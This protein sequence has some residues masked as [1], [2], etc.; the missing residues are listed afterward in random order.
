MTFLILISPATVKERVSTTVGPDLNT[1]TSGRTHDI[2]IPLAKEYTY[3]YKGVLVGKGR[4]AIFTSS[5]YE[6]KMIWQA[7]HPH[8]M[9]FELI[10]DSGL[11]GF[12]IMI[13]IFSIVGMNIFKSVSAIKDNKL[14]YYQCAIIVSIIAYL[15]TGLTGRSL[16]PILANSYF[17]IVLGCGIAISRMN[18]DGVEG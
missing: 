14:R 1:A 6:N 4:F 11:L 18:L 8:N 5:T 7:A 2:W 13:G 12:F 17:W 3:D 9:Y 16:F 10:L 15:I